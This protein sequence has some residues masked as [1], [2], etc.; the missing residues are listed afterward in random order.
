MQTNT[1]F[2]SPQTII[3]NGN[4]TG[5]PW[6][7]P[8]NLLTLNGSY[9]STPAVLSA[10][11]DVVVGNFIFGT[12]IPQ[13]SAI[14]GI[15][16]SFRGYR[17]PTADPATAL[18][19]YAYD[20]TNG[21]NFFYELTPVFSDFTTAPVTYY[22]GS[23]SFLFNTT[24][25]VDQ[26]NNLKIRLQGNGE[27]F[28]DGI[29][30]RVTYSPAITGTSPDQSLVSRIFQAQPFSIVSPISA[31]AGDYYW[32]VNKFTTS[33]N[34]P[35]TNA[36]IVSPGIPI[37]V[38]QGNSNEENAYVVGITPTTSGQVMLQVS[39]AWSFRD[40]NIQSAQPKQHSAGAELIIGN[41][42]QFYDL[43]VRKYQVDT[44]FAPPIPVKD[45][46]TQLTS[47]V[48]S[49]NFVGSG[50]VATN[51][52]HD[53]TVT[54]AGS[55]TNPPQ[56][57]G[58]GTGG[59]G[60]VQIDTITDTQVTTTG[61]DR[62][63]AVSI[64]TESGIAVSSATFNGVSLVHQHTQTE[65]NV[66]VELWTLVAPTLGTH[67][68]VINT[69][70]NTYIGYTWSFFNAVNQTTPFTLGGG[71][72]NNTNT[73][74]G[75][76]TTTTD[77]A[78]VLHTVGTKLVGINYTAGGGESLIQKYII[79]VVQSGME[80]QNVG[81]PALVT[82][83]IALSSATNWANILGYINGV[84]PPG[85]SI[86]VEDE[87]TPIVNTN[88]VNFVGAGV[89][90]TDVLGVA[91]VT[92]PGG[93][94]SSLEVEENGVSIE[95]GVD[96]INFTGAG[97]TVTNPSPGQVDV[98]ISGGGGSGS[99]VQ[100]TINQTAHGFVVG[101]VIRSSGT[102]GQYTK[103]Q[104]NS[105]ANAEVV[106]IVTQ[107]IDVDNFV[108]TTEGYFTSGVPVASAGTIMFLSD[109]VAGAITP[110][111]PV[112]V[113]SVSKPVVTIITSGSI[114]YFHNYRGQ[115]NQ[116]TPASTSLFTV[117]S[118]ENDTEWHTNQV[119]N[120]TGV[121]PFGPWTYSFTPTSYANG[122]VFSANGSIIA[123]TTNGIIDEVIPGTYSFIEWA[124]NRTLKIKFMAVSETPSGT[125]GSQISSFV[126]FGSNVTTSFGDIT[127]ATEERV[128]FAFY[129]GN[130][131]I[132]S[133]NSSAI[134]ATLIDSYVNQNDQYVVQLNGT[135]SADF[136][137]NG[138]LVGSISTNIPNSATRFG[139]CVGGI[140]SSGAAGF[141]FI[142]NFVISQKTS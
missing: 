89:T 77:N 3:S 31:N 2:V 35:I 34:V 44:V 85:V 134:T 27:L 119:I 57:G 130:R 107:V 111:E 40:P 90:V 142:S 70:S 115:E 46:G 55:T 123:E 15:E 38:D 126:G 112:A 75:S 86:S 22:F 18:Q 16:I 138:V 132:V 122:T 74:T 36:D 127:V 8:D 135:S 58:G 47:S 96:T 101:N 100:Q 5:T 84:T 26:I 45:E 78:L 93:G 42:V 49:F 92:I 117:N 110:T 54:I 41:S 67:N 106:G 9:A 91:T 14:S 39:R 133:S 48:H 52:G 80:T 21:N 88:T 118:D 50:V 51:V 76:V 30:I 28:I 131:Y 69:A 6:L 114:G 23:S 128:G 136:Y 121:S 59:S 19:I 97:V 11:A 17:G 68:L 71:N 113:T 87:G 140:A 81:T 32:L 98:A 108:V 62:F 94:G 25:T 83:N 4:Y 82:S 10:G 43:F 53:V 13:N 72:G 105:T 37:T 120:P 79:G 124:T 64:T 29:Q 116:T 125:G 141:K 99:A 66:R 102:A 139:I 12:P 56:Q 24:W 1:G 109:S 33:D 60:G 20:N 65:G 61:T 104:A 7:N 63:L 129:N 95:T 103:S 73:A 137:I